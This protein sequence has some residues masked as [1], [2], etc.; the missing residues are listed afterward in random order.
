M[1]ANAFLAIVL[2]SLTARLGYQMAR[3]PVLPQFAADLGAA[4]ELLGLIVGASTVTGV[5]LKLPAGA[6]SDVLGR[7]RMLIAGALFFALPPFFYPLIAE[8]YGLLALRFVHGTATAVF[9][10]VAAAYVADLARAER[11]AR[12]GT[13][14]AANDAGA[15]LGP[16][17]GGAILFWSAS[18]DAVY[19]TVAALGVLALAAAIALPAPPAA[20]AATGEDGSRAERFRRGLAEVL[21]TPP[22]LIAAAVEAAMYL[23]FGAFLGFLPL[24]AEA[25]GLNEAAIGAV[26]AAQ[27][28]VAIAA[29]PVTGRVS[30]RIGR[31][32]VIVLGLIACAAALPLVFRSQGLGPLLAGAALLGIGVALVTPATNALVA[33]L[34]KRHRLGAAMGVFGTIWDIGEAMGPIAA[35]FLLGRLGYATTFDVLA[36]VT[37]GAAFVFAVTVRTPSAPAVDRPTPP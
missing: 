24:Y 8:P 29:K 15:A 13:F 33:D 17:A 6:L 22:V 28:A 14:S 3:S 5:F 36:G 21:R 26:L 4:P 11:G 20:Q 25:Q 37:L 12:L 10:P 34:V 16:L 30:D 2:A 1:T 23:G 18:Y 32:P 7:R 27:V 35:G 31:K 9:S 19:L